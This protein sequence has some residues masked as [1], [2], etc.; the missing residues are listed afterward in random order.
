MGLTQFHKSFNSRVRSEKYKVQHAISG[1]SVRGQTA[2]DYRQPLELRDSEET[3]K[4]VPLLQETEFF[5]PECAWKG[6]PP[7]TTDEEWPS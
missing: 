5:Q 4:S 7:A 1:L 3:G 2:G 6:L